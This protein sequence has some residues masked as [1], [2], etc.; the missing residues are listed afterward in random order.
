MS[1]LIKN[2]KKYDLDIKGVRLP[3][4]NISLEE[5]ERVGV[6]KDCSNFDFLKALCADKL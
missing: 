2:F 1:N 4:F 3:S 6:D 5:K